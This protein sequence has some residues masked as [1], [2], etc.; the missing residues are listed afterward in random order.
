MKNRIF[1][2]ALTMLIFC[3]LTGC[4]GIAE[5]SDQIA[6]DEVNLYEG[7]TM[8]VVE[9][10]VYPGSAA[11]EILNVTE[12][13]I[14]SGNQFDFGLQKEVDG[15]WYWMETKESEYCNTAE[16]IGYPT[17]EP[18]VQE[19]TWGSVYGALAEGHYRIV[20]AFFE[21]RGPGDCTDFLLAAEFEVP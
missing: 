17:G 10:S 12:K 7:V 8:T 21:Y 6:A 14:E 18:V 3:F 11:V 4:G 15:A 5:V 9:G 1:L 16:A 20:K 2:T 13:D 19:L